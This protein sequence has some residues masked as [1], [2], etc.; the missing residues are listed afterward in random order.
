MAAF[1]GAAFA[2]GVGTAAGVGDG[3]ASDFVDARATALDDFLH[4]GAVYGH[5]DDDD[6]TQSLPLGG[7]GTVQVR[8]GAGLLCLD[9]GFPLVPLTGRCGCGGDSVRWTSPGSSG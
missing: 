8:W 9:A 2:G 3:L 1:G 6:D 5:S 4:D 7:G